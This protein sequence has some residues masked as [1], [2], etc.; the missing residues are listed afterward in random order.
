MSTRIMF[1]TQLNSTLNWLTDRALAS[2]RTLIFDGNKYVDVQH[3]LEVTA[4]M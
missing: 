2:V 4:H 1:Y 3:V